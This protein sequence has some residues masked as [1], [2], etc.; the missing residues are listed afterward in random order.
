MWHSW[1]WCPCWGH[2][3][4][5]IDQFDEASFFAK[6]EALGLCHGEVGTTCWF[7]LQ[8]GSVCFIGSEAVESNQGPG[9]VVRAFVRKKIPDEVT[10]TSG[11]DGAP[12]LCVL[13]ERISLVRI[14]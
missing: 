3:E 9:H 6:N 4:R 11:D 13:F 14:D 7:C 8:V 5:A 1:C 10:A 2:V 12:V